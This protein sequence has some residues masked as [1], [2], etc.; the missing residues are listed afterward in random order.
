IF[1]SLV[2]SFTTNWILRVA[3]GGQA[4]N[5]SGYFS[6]GTFEMRSASPLEL[7]LFVI[8][9]AAG[10]V[11]GALFNAIGLRLKRFR[12]RYIASTTSKIVESM[13]VS[14]ATSLVGVAMII[15]ADDY[16]MRPTVLASVFLEYYGLTVWTAGLPLSTCMFVP[17]LLTGAIAGRFCAYCAD[18]AVVRLTAEEL[19]KY[20]VASAA[21]LVAGVTRMTVSLAAIVIEST[22]NVGF[23]LPVMLA[24][25]VAKLVGVC[26]NQG[27]YDIQIEEADIP[28]MPADPPKHAESVPV[29]N[30]MHREVVAFRVHE[31]AWHISDILR[32]TTHKAFPVVDRIAEPLIED[33][34]P[35]FGHLLG[36]VSRRQLAERL[37]A[38]AASNV[39]MID[40]TEMVQRAPQAVR[41]DAPLKQILQIFQ[42]FPV[43]VVVV[44]N[45]RNQV[46]GIISRKDL[47]RYLKPP[48]TSGQ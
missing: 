9:G 13:M 2:A 31:P 46:R 14:F 11:A 47:V 41:M 23:G 40:L 6:F 17:L 42:C 48:A 36:M 15:L 44:V 38:H 32:T 1:T 19:A 21:A 4:M 39:A 7:P 43:R 12:R 10:G 34:Y 29:K 33:R 37:D 45:E 27:I 26:F 3:L 22:G 20:E 8:I 28:F 25:V 35:A 24:L 16:S 5:W 30:L 18:A